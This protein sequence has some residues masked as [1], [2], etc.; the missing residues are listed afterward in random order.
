MVL[1]VMVVS[2]TVTCGGRRE[3]SKLPGL[4][5]NALSLLEFSSEKKDDGWGADGAEKEELLVWGAG[6]RSER[7]DGATDF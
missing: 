4:C 2:S 7:V 3:L 5:C 6:W 1:P